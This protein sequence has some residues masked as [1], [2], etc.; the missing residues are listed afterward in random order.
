[1]AVGL[2]A[3]SACSG[4]EPGAICPVLLLAVDGIE[5]RVV[6]AMLAEGGLPNFARFAAE[7]ALGRLGTLEETYSPV[8]W[9]SV[10]TGQK[11]ADHGID[12]F[13]ETQS[14]LPYTSDCRRVPALWNLV[15]DAGLTVD[16]V[17]WWV[18]WPAEPI[19][20]RMLASY[21]AQAQAQVIWKASY[22]G[23]IE[24]QTWPPELWDEIRSD[25]LFASDT[26]AALSATA[27]RFPLPPALDQDPADVGRMV[28][29]LAWTLAADRTNAA[30]TERFLAD[31]PGDLVLSYLALPDVAGHRFWR[32]HEPEAY[33][34]VVPEASVAALGDYLR[35]AYLDVDAAIGRL[36]DRVGPEWTVLVVSDHGMHADPSTLDD[37]A[38]LGSGHHRGPVPGVVA[39][40][41]PGIARLGNQLAA[42]ELGHVL[43]VAPFVLRR[44]GL[45]RP[46]H[47][48]SVMEQAGLERT[49]LSAEWSASHAALSM[50]PPDRDWL[51]A[52]PRKPPSAPGS[53]SGSSEAFLEAFES[54]GY[55]ERGE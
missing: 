33:R 45:A 54:L 11:V 14:G 48:P 21:A 26:D 43:D 28:T 29:D 46:S 16:V 50:A 7:G 24:D 52:H 34:Y 40:I 37:P 41:G 17:G 1:M 19:R 47:W 20:G 42:P 38:A 8:V 31:R 32:Y 44:L 12:F 5:P 4:G 55:F 15:G 39:A 30:V 6:D 51:K 2:S 53:G 25:V 23:D 36:L 27:E 18:T 9:T 22:F 3:V 10:A 13:F 49:L 35:R